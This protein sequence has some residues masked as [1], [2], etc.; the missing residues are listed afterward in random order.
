MHVSTVSQHVTP[1]M[2]GVSLSCTNTSPFPA[3]INVW[4]VFHPD[5]DPYATHSYTDKG[6]VSPHELM[7]RGNGDGTETQNPCRGHKDYMV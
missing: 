1:V 5:F 3:S 7:S 2:S 4:D 6:V